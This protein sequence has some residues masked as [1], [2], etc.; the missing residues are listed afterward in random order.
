MELTEQEKDMVLEHR[1]KQVVLTSQKRYALFCLETAYRYEQW[2]Q[3][4]SNGSTYSTF[5]N[6]FGFDSWGDYSRS[7]TFATVEIIRELAYKST[8]RD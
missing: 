3:A 8:H 7:Q 2:L 1:K 4:N 5:C 6:D